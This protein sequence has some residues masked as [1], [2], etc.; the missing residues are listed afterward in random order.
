MH[1]TGIKMATNPEHANHGMT[2]YFGRPIRDY[3]LDKRHRISVQIYYNRHNINV[4][5]CENNLTISLTDDTDNTFTMM[6]GTTNAAA[7]RY[8]PM[9]LTGVITSMGVFILVDTGVMHNI[10]DINVVRAIGLREQ[11][12]DTTI[13]ID[14]G[15]KVTC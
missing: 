9:F 11:R 6:I 2:E 4:Y 10:I 12:I 13:L 14:S 15:T 3:P 1:L 8:T 7:H 5:K